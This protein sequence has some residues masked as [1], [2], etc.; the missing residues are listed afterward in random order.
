M[1]RINPTLVSNIL[2]AQSLEELHP[3][4]QGAIELEHS[5]IPPYLTALF[6]FK[7]GKG[8][9]VRPIIESIV[10][11]EMLHMTIASNILNALN[12]RPQIDKPAFVPNYK[13]PLP[14]GINVGFE[15]GLEKCSI[16]VVQNVFMEI[17]EPETI[18]NINYA[19]KATDTYKTIGEFYG[20]LAKKIDEL[21]PD[22][23]PGDPA[24]QVV[25]NNYFPPDEL[26]AIRTK[27]DA[28]AAID[29][30]VEQ[31][32]GTSTEPVDMY[33]EVAHYYRF[34]EI[35]MGKKLIKDPHADHG[36]SYSGAPVPFSNDDV[37][38]IFPTTKVWMLPPGSEQ[39]HRAQEFNYFYTMLL[40]GLHR[41]FNGEPTFLS[42]TMGLMYDVKLTGEKL[43]EMKFPGKD[44]F[45]V[46]PTFEY[47]KQP[48][49][50]M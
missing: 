36:Y 9:E 45:Y 31:G 11:E 27:Q 49:Q 22:I 12:G 35:V 30:I 16:D 14:M 43:C 3:M 5:T 44:G 1:L 17:E 18:L 15:V 48:P 20:A 39:W 21:A 37:W 2:S 10:I 34:K 7:R 13:C 38:N 29:I 33:G 6:S 47:Q 32:E 50:Q 26:F 19:V 28:I 8:K 24:K 46:G 23:M 42:N 40:E 4:V 41:T 25:A